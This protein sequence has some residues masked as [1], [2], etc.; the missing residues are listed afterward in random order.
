MKKNNVFRIILSMILIVILITGCGSNSDVIETKNGE[1]LK[2]T[3]SVTSSIEYEEFNN[4]LVKMEIPKGWKV[5]I[6]KVVTYSGYSFR[7]YNP[8]NPD[9]GYMFSL[10]LSGFPKTEADRAKFYSYYP[11]AVF[12]NLAAVDPHNTEG[13]YKV[14]AK[15][16]KYA[17]TYQLKEEFF[18]VTT[19][20]KMIE[21]L[22][23]T[24]LGGD[25]LRGTYISSS[26]EKLQALVT[27]TVVESGIDKMLG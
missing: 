18:I 19:D 24:P 1:K 15:N 3:K 2:I 20:W 26:G 23:N 16:A 11:S 12:G 4:G 14:W 22:G 7:V 13:F 21:N 6:P 17:N 5:Y 9:I 10:A 27:S 25:V 8:D